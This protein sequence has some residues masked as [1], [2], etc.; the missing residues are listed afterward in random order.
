MTDELSLETRAV[1]LGRPH[2]VG[3]P[4]NAPLVLTST[5][6]AGGALGYA[7]EGTPTWLALEEVL[8]ALEDGYALTFSSGMGA[9]NAVLDLLPAGAIVVAP[10]HP[11]SGTGARLRELHQV[12]RITTRIVAMDSTDEVVQALDGA[13]LLWI[14]TPTNPLME[15]ADVRRLAVEATQR[16][17]RTVVDNTFAT[18]ILQRPLDLGV[19]ITMQ[20]ATKFIAGHSDSLLGVLTTKDLDLRDQLK[21]RRSLMG[22][23]P[24]A[25][26]TW[27]ALRGVRTL[28]LRM[29]QATQN[30]AVIAERLLNTAGVTQVLYPGLPQHP[31]HDIAMSQMTN[32]GAI[33]CFVLEGSA[34]NA[35]RVCNSTRLWTHATSLGGVESTL[36]RRARWSLESPDVP[37]NLIRLSVG[38][39]DVEDLWRDLAQALKG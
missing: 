29:R 31:G 16:G 18:P 28:V 11:Y 7:R 9:I 5:Y 21:A 15:I 10:N 38:I 14:E 25:M 26:E 35:E 12:G 37:T 33:V 32:G 8:G 1:A 4:L 39:E 23:N 17:V 24:G 6:A 13:A 36:E 3:Q 27:L 19:D 2:G 22:L 20:S 30:A 34:E